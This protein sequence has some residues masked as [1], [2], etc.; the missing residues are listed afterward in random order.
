VSILAR[1]T[2]GASD[3]TIP[4]APVQRSESPTEPGSEGGAALVPAAPARR[5]SGR[6]RRLR[7][8]LA[9]VP[10]LSVGLAIVSITLLIS[11]SALAFAEPVVD[12]R[13]LS[14]WRDLA[15]CSGI[16]AVILLGGS[17]IS[18]L[19]RGSWSSAPSVRRSVARSHAFPAALSV[20]FT[21]VHLVA[22]FAAPELSIGWLQLLVPGTRQDAPLAQACAVLA[23]YLMF[24]IIVTSALRRMLSPRWWHRIHQGALPLFGLAGMHSVLAE[25]LTEASVHDAPI[26]RASCCAIVALLGALLLLRFHRGPVA[27]VQ[28][29]SSDRLDPVASFGTVAASAP[30]PPVGRAHLRSLLITQTT[31]EATGVVSL[32]LAAPLGECL[33]SWQP[34]AHVQVVLPSGRARLYSLCGDRLDRGRYRIAVLCQEYG[35]GA[36]W[37]IHHELRVGVRLLV[38]PPRNGFTLQPAPGYLFLAG[39]IGITAIL[40]MVRAMIGMGQPW[41]MIYAGR[42]RAK[43]AFL[44]EVAGLHPYRST[45]MP[46]DE[47]GRPNLAEL[48]ARQQSGTAVYCCGPDGMVDALREVIAARPD[49]SLHTESFR[50]VA[51]PRTAKPLAVELRRSGTRLEVSAEQTILDA[52]RDLA[53]ALDGGCERGICGRCTVTVLNGEPEHR[54]SYLTERQR[55][56]GQM[57]ICVSGAT[58]NRL[59]LDL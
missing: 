43:M 55:R 21:V 54:D 56:Q 42:C 36:S 18:G 11:T 17:V 7:S 46:E 20:V 44:N 58:S 47:L 48:I 27:S 53:P 39:G 59:V 57:L 9:W 32:V 26:H 45:I 15:R 1:S 14:E 10:A 41:R 29:P 23:V 8:Y 28:R 12:G 4:A 35:W 50:G 24:A 30:V 40:P 52:V 16:L 2:A 37:E 33:P 5:R 34:G 3:D 25:N 31:R 13:P 19:A 22:V 49:L 38:G 51:T 6:L